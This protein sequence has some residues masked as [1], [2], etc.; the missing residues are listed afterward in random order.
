M[1]L[2]EE[3]MCSADC[4]C[5]S[6]AQTKYR[7]LYNDAKGKERFTAAKRYFFDSPPAGI[8]IDSSWKYLVFDATGTTTT[9]TQYSKCYTDK[10]ETKFKDDTNQRI[11]D[12]YAG[13][14]KDGLA[15]FQSM[16]KE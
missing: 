14:K 12:A 13:F 9:Y 1:M 7:E 3:Y 5:P 4:P 6:E 8:T 15:Y 11:K 10:L 2:I 16:E